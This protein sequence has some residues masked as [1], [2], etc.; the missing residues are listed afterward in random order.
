MVD[1]S[2]YHQ[3]GSDSFQPSNLDDRGQHWMSDTADKKWVGKSEEEW[4]KDVGDNYTLEAQTYDERR[5]VHLNARFF[6]EVSYGVLNELLGDVPTGAV[7]MDMPV[8]TGRFLFY[9]RDHGR[10]HDMLGVDISQGMLKVCSDRAKERGER[11]PVM[12]GDA[13]RICLADNSV[14]VLSSLRFFHLFPVEYWP[15]ILKEMF[16]VLKPGGV[17]LVDLRN[18]FRFGVWG[19]VKEL[20]DR[21][22]HKDQPHGF[23]SPTRLRSLFADWELEKT[24]GVGVD[25]TPHLSALSPSLA[26]RLSRLGRHW[27]WKYLTKEIVIKAR[28]PV[29]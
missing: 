10:T 29:S 6:F 2:V 22:I 18:I 20:R 23:L 1:A 15:A 17:L 12:F 11:L 19:I 8:G 28:K 16:R 14:D 26:H 24:V 25:G 9:L 13:F 3:Q 21:W 7:H 5:S 27:P 4:R